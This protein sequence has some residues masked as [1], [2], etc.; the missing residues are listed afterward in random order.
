MTRRAVYLA[1][2]LSAP[3]RAGI[4]A[5]RQSASK[6]AAF[7]VTHFNVAIECSWIVLTGELDETPENR[8]RGLDCDL[9]MVG[10]CQELVMVG[11]RTSDGMLIEAR[12]MVHEVG[13]AVYDLTGLE[14]DP[15]VVGRAWTGGR[16]FP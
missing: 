2:C 3:T 4:E 14:M 12:H 5:N 9:V 6:W 8:K 7:L 16:W 10:G 11:P 1:H 15:G 13:G